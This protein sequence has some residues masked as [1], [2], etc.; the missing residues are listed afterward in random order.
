MLPCPSAGLE[1][2]AYRFD[3]QGFLY[4]SLFDYHFYKQEKSSRILSLLLLS[5][6]ERSGSGTEGLTVQRLR[7]Y[8]STHRL[9]T[10][11]ERKM[12][13][14]LSLAE[15]AMISS[16]PALPCTPRGA[17]L[18]LYPAKRG[19]VQGFARAHTCL[20]VGREIAE[21][22]IEGGLLFVPSGNKQKTFSLCTTH[23]QFLEILLRFSRTILSKLF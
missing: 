23:D 14:H 17:G 16:P 11:T 20:P 5:A 1:N 2:P 3:T 19:T 22:L 7:E 18:A 21:R 4:T 15:Y 10:Q 12:M 8:N 9:I 13:N 6:V